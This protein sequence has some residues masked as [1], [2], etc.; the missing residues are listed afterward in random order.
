METRS[1][2][3]FSIRDQLLADFS[4]GLRARGVLEGG[5]ICSVCSR[6]TI[7]YEARVLM[8]REMKGPFRY[9]LLLTLHMD[10]YICIYCTT[11]Y[12]KCAP[13]KGGGG[14]QDSRSLS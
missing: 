5:F 12:D 7:F 4:L 2:A 9:H 3:E 13:P 11:G 10:I 1:P 14:V 8:Q 6:F